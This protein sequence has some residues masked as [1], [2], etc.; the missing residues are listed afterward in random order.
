[1]FV[2]MYGGL[3]RI[4]LARPSLVGCAKLGDLNIANRML[5]MI[6]LS[7]S[8]LARGYPLPP[9]ILVGRAGQNLTNVTVGGSLLL[10]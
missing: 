3:K 10:S 7:R 2:T 5:T 9:L 1:M 6:G 8:R 4:L